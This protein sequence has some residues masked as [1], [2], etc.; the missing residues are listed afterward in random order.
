MV[1]KFIT[2]AEQQIVVGADFNVA[3]DPDL[4]CS[5]GHVESILTGY[6]QNLIDGSQN[7]V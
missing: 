4:D 5:G 3:I 1:E 2:S 6:V 7:A